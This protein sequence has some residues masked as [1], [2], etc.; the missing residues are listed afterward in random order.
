KSQR[1]MAAKVPKQVGRGAGSE[2]A[3]VRPMEPQCLV[4]CGDFWIWL[5]ATLKN[6]LFA[7]VH[8]RRPRALRRSL[9]HSANVRQFGLG[10][11]G[12]LMD[13][14]VGAFLRDDSRRPSTRRAF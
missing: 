3:T 7:V 11:G 8:N 10:I 14:C 1:T 13:H 6:G 12:W 4:S 9:A 2:I 5:E